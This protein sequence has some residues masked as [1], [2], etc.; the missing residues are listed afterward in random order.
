MDP[1]KV[2]PPP[3]LLLTSSEMLL[4]TLRITL[5]SVRSSKLTSTT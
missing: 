2:P 3:Y 5:R 4:G 1:D